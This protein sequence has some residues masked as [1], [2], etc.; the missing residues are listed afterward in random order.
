MQEPKPLDYSVKR[1]GW[2]TKTLS[3]RGLVKRRSST[4][5]EVPSRDR[6]KNMIPKLNGLEWNFVVEPAKSF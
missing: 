1:L 2:I 3:T 6:K 5:F 4:V